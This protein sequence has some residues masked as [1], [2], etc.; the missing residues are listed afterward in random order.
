MLLPFT[1]GKGLQGVVTMQYDIDNLT[2]KHLT[3]L[4]VNRLSVIGLLLE[5]DMKLA[6]LPTD[7]LALQNEKVVLDNFL[8][9]IQ[10]G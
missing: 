9:Q 6:M 7:V 5:P 4:I 8:N 1:S 2:Y 3:Q 10:R